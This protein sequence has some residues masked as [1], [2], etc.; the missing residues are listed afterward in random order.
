M[1][2]GARLRPALDTSL[3]ADN[4][5]SVERRPTMVQGKLHSFE[6][7]HESHDSGRPFPAYP[8]G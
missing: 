2:G 8:V 3:A 4:Q 1:D 5:G 6:S 7:T